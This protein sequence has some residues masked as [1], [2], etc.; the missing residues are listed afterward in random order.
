[1]R[2][3]TDA[4]IDSARIISNLGYYYMSLL[5]AIGTLEDSELEALEAALNKVLTAYENFRK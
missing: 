4:T 3:R 1:M 5:S 2:D